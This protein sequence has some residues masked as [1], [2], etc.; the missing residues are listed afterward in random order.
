MKILILLFLLISSSF[1]AKSKIINAYAVSI[2]DKHLNEENVQTKRITEKDYDGL[3]YTKIYMFGNLYHEKL[4][5]VIGNSV[6][7]LSKSRNI[8]KN[9]K[10]IGKE[11]TYKHY[12]V[13]KGY[14]KISTKKKIY[15]QKVFVK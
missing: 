1:S 12:S 9:K 10:L 2:Y 14:L 3:T 15:D 7:Y 13:T 4:R 8:T 5:V 6:G 11:L